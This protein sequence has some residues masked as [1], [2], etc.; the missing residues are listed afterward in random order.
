MKE[1]AVH[2]NNVLR[3]MIEAFSDDKASRCSLHVVFIDDRG[4]FEEGR[5]SGVTREALSNFWR[6]FFN[7]LAIG[8]AE[9]VPAIRHDLQKNEWQSVARILVAGFSEM[10]YF[11]VA[12]SRAFVA[13]CLFPEELLSKEWLLQSFHLYS[14]K[15][16]SKD[17]S[18]S[19]KRGLSVEDPSQDEDILEV[20][21]SYKCYRRVEKATMTKIMEELAHQELIQRPKYV[22]NAWHPIV[23][24]L[25]RHEEFKDLQSLVQLYEAK[26][27]TTKR[28]CKLS[29][30]Q[31]VSNSERECFEHLKRFVKSL[32]D[33]LFGA[34][35]QFITGSNILTVDK[36][37]VGFSANTGATR[38]PVAHTCAPLLIVPSTY[39]SYNE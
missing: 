15:D 29:E 19:L 18:D 6:E 10:G 37:Q 30:A 7:S 2:R 35:L 28:V 12:L 16:S 17:E 22:A 25:T 36:I 13:S 21:T 8:A 34:F 24:S 4:E 5:G 3:G 14:S 27:P 38:S 33:N 11:P 1:V 39:Q 32:D 31:P 26:V 20:L 9:K 23:K